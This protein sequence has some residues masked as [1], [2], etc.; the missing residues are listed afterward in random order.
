MA[1]SDYTVQTVQQD[2]VSVS[3]GTQ[4]NQ[5]LNLNYLLNRAARQ[6]LADVDPA[7][8]IRY[9]LSTT[10]FYD[11]VYDYACP[12]D[13]KGNGIIDISPQG[14]ERYPSQVLQQ[15]FNQ[16]FNVN[17]SLRPGKPA[18]T[19]KWNSQVK[20]IQVNDP[21]LPYPIVLDSMN[22]VGNW[23]VGANASNLITNNINFVSGSGSLQF[24]T[25][26]GINPTVATISE[27]LSSPINLSNDL[28]QASFFMYI[29]FPVAANINSVTLNVGTDANDY[30]S[31]KQTLTHSGTSFANA[32]NLVQFPWLGATVVGTPNPANINYL[33]VSVSTN[34]T[35]TTGIL[36]DNITCNMGLYRQIEYYSKYLF[37]NATTGAF[38]EG[39]TQSTDII[40]LDTD[41][42]NLY[43]NLVAYYAAQ[44]MQGLDALFYDANFFLTQYQNA[45]V[46]YK[47]LNPSER[48]KQHAAYYTKRKGGYQSYIGRG[49]RN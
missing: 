44:E 18:F 23:I 28:N 34:G 15:A 20:T 42:Y 19:I 4:I 1:V 49:F 9:T 40:A 21:T 24:N 37:I 32:W 2:L 12:V 29:Y 46:R 11:K 41:T 14:Q 22:V 3:H 8:T 10:P 47:Q 26:T 36:V 30:Y 33:S 25:A 38:M 31:V 35:A 5:I 13:L 17:K 43:F 6:L 27:T 7:E 39:T 48:N 16:D 45:L